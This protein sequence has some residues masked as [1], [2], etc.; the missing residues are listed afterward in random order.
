M[1]RKQLLLIVPTEPAETGNG[2]AMRAGAHLM[3]LARLFDVHL[4]IVPL[5]D[6]P[7]AGDAFLDRHAA[8]VGRLDLG[9]HLDPLFGL[10]ARL[11]DPEERHRALL[12]YRKPLLG[13]FC[14][15]ESAAAVRDWYG[16]APPHAVHVMRLYL[17]PLAARFRRPAGEARPLL[18]LDL[19]DDE[20]ATRP[21]LAALH[22]AAGREREA[23]RDEAESRKYLAWAE[24]YFG[25]FDR[26]LVCSESDAARLRR[27]WNGVR[28]DVL[29]NVVAAPPEPAA[30][31]APGP[32]RLLF[33]GNLSYAPNEDAVTFLVEE[34]LPRLRGLT[35]REVLLDIVGGGAGAPLERIMA[36]GGVRPRGF[37]EELAP[38]YREAAAALAPIRAGGGTRLKILEAFAHGVPV[39]ATPLGAEGLDV[40]NERHLLI[41]GDGEAFAAACLRLM[42]DPEL[43]ARLARNARQL[44]RERYGLEAAGERLG[45]IYGEVLAGR[46]K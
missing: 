12:G 19:D 39:V 13:R 8:R 15:S 41:A 3:A 23:E 10:M 45:E 46:R 26:V 6:S 7:G 14:T 22:R 20:T 18:A 44:V 30:R 40:A 27:R 9:A 43:A 5:F 29:P 34:V 1:P 11:K 33:V 25:D 4:F 32:S 28:F 16:R 21:R 35:D 31:A 37:V 24:C 42:S 17:A 36:A 2:L 38:V